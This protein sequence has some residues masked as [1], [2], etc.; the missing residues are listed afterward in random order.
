MNSTTSALL[1]DMMWLL[2]FPYIV[3]RVQ[4]PCFASLWVGENDPSCIF[5]FLSVMV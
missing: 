5:H 2:A 1:S 4:A 3:F